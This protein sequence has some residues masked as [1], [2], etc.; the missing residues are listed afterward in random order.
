[1]GV[2][3][4]DQHRGPKRTGGGLTPKLCK[5]QVFEEL[6][7]KNVVYAVRHARSNSNLSRKAR[8]NM[9]LTKVT[10]TLLVRTPDYRRRYF[11]RNLFDEVVSYE[12]YLKGKQ[13]H[14]NVHKM[15][16]EEMLELML[17]L[18]ARE[19]DGLFGFQVYESEGYARFDL[20]NALKYLGDPPPE[21]TLKWRETDPKTERFCRARH[22]RLFRCD[23]CGHTLRR[24]IT[25]T[26]GRDFVYPTPPGLCQECP[27]PVE[28][29]ALED[30]YLTRMPPPF[31]YDPEPLRTAAVAALPPLKSQ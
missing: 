20:E 5:S 1:M 15:S 17:P 22:Q 2:V 19:S 8:Q 24:V 25:W 6:N 26:S 11:T 27:A 23:W 12:Q 9:D 29:D 28:M 31:E 30:F 16:F 4:A 10:D 13:W 14:K 21:A 7:S 3:A 18:S